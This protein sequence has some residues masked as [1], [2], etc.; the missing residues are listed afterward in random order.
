[1]LSRIATAVMAAW[2]AVN[3]TDPAGLHAHCPVHGAGAADHSADGHMHGSHTEHYGH[4]TG[5][6]SHHESD[7]AQHQC[8][9][10]GACFCTAALTVTPERL[11]ALPVVPVVV[12]RPTIAEVDETPRVARPDLVLPPPLGPPSLQV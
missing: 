8:C 5:P 11:V 7:P 4:G 6:G 2:L 1:M 12:I 9:C 10:I 3:L